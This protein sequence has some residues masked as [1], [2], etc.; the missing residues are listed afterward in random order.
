MTWAPKRVNSGYLNLTVMKIETWTQKCFEGKCV[1]TQTFDGKG[2][3]ICAS[4]ILEDYSEESFLL[5]QNA[6]GLQPRTHLEEWC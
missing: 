4:T 2:I 5:Y 3:Y 1:S 6:S